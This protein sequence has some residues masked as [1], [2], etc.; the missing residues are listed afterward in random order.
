MDYNLFLT[1][2]YLRDV[3]QALKEGKTGKMVVGKIDYQAIH[4][5]EEFRAA[6]ENLM[7]K[8]PEFIMGFNPILKKEKQKVVGLDGKG[9]VISFEKMRYTVS[10]SAGRCSR[11]EFVEAEKYFDDSIPIRDFNSSLDNMMEK[12]KGSQISGN[13]ASSICNG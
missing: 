6:Y 9:N 11:K 3:E 12:F 8:Y 1:K 5:N 4:G 7:K 10:G 13:K 2:E